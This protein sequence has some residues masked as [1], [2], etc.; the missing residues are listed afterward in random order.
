M[1]DAIQALSEKSEN[2]DSAANNMMVA[3]ESDTGEEVPAEQDDDLFDE[4]YDEE[5]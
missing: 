1:S 4:E 3:E 5:Y 2:I